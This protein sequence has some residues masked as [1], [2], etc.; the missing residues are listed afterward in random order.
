MLDRRGCARL[1]AW[2]LVVGVAC[3]EA[4][5]ENELSNA[6]AHTS[7]ARSAAGD[8]PLA[9]E[10]ENGEATAPESQ[11]PPRDGSQESTP[12]R[13]RGGDPARRAALQERRI[14]QREAQIRSLVEE[15]KGEV[16]LDDAQAE[17]ISAIMLA[18][19]KKLIELWR[20]LQ[21]QSRPD[22][23]EKN[24]EIR[25]QML[26]ARA[27]GDEERME[28]LR[29]RFDEE[30]LGEIGKFR[31]PIRRQMREIR[32]GKKT[33]LAILPLLREEQVAPFDAFWVE[34]VAPIQRP[35]PSAESLRASLE[36]LTDLTPVQK[37]RV[38]ALFREYESDRLNPPEG[39]FGWAVVL[40]QLY[41]DVYGVLTEDQRA[42]VQEYEKQREMLSQ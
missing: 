12:Q 9:G 4:P 20:A 30:Y 31:R 10:R 1:L 33:R 17:Q 18:Q 3:D 37:Q 2:M 23:L 42:V 24:R 28:Q 6:A 34:K 27:A 21:I 38:D 11:T 15:M 29:K 13:A 8:A 22:L 14:A 5:S 25:Q 35:L 36:R 19:E 41:D 26:E 16:N 7:T 40:K 39:Q 32:S